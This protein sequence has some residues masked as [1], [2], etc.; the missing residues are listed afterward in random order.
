M[1]RNV[2][3]LPATERQ[4]LEAIIGQP[5]SPGQR[6]FIMAYTP[7]AVPDKSVREAARV[8]LQRTFDKIDEYA[9]A[10]SVSPEEADAATEE[11]MQ[12][13]RPRKG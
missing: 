11:A 13:V 1:S 5:L 3:D 12:N 9:A 7:N 6:V 2:N 10:I 8:G 4:T